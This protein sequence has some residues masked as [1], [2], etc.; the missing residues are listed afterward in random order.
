[1][2]P[3]TIDGVPEPPVC[4]MPDPD[5]VK[6]LRQLGFHYVRYRHVDEGL[7]TGIFEL[8]REG[9]VVFKVNFESWRLEPA[10]TDDNLRHA[11][12]QWSRRRQPHS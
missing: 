5:L 12:E 7:Y 4:P 3:R 11:A 9:E 10:A 1:M 8:L 2:E 6:G